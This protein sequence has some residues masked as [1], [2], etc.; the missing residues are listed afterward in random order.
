MKPCR[1]SRRAALMWGVDRLGTLLR[2]GKVVG[3]SIHTPN[4]ALTK[5]G[6][7]GGYGRLMA[8]SLAVPTSKDDL[9]ELFLSSRN[10]SERS[11]IDKTRPRGLINT[12]AEVA[13]GALHPAR[14]P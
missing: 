8:E 11:H 14:D 6:E 10:L 1:A 5:V 9:D 2:T 7:L 12:Q 4:S 3:S 13:A